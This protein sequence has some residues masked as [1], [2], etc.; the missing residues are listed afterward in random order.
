MQIPD[1]I[2][3]LWQFVYICNCVLDMGRINVDGV[4]G[5]IYYN[6]FERNFP[7][8]CLLTKVSL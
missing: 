2:L 1:G 3:G 6:G 4:S 7:H 8:S 5:I